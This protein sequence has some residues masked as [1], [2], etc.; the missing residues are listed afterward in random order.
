MGTIKDHKHEV[1]EILNGLTAELKS[2]INTVRKFQDYLEEKIIKDINGIQNKYK[3]SA[4]R[5]TTENGTG[6]WN[7]PDVS[8]YHPKRLDASDKQREDP[9]FLADPIHGDVPARA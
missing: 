2:T 9:T 3:A 6:Q 4:Q 1:D 5:G 7:G 8:E